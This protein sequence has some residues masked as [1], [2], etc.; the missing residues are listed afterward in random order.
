M[1]AEAKERVKAKAKNSVK[2]NLLMLTIFYLLFLVIIGVTK[3]PVRQLSNLAF[4]PVH[5]QKN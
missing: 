5:S 4:V 2:A 3:A 1:P